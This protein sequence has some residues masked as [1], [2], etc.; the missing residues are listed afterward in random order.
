MRENPRALSAR[1]VGGRVAGK[2]KEKVGW[3]ADLKGE[4]KGNCGSSS[5]EEEISGNS[6]CCLRR[7]RSIGNEV[8]SL[9][10]G[11]F[12]HRIGEQWAFVEFNSGFMIPFEILTHLIGMSGVL[13]KP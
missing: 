2:E 8:G 3:S 5:T 6:C 10:F 11:E 9:I 13:S 7:R 4:T 1:V 12:L